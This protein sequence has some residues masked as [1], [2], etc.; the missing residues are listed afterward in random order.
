MRPRKISPSLK[1]LPLSLALGLTTQAGQVFAQEENDEELERFQVTG[2]RID[3]DVEGTSPTVSFDR[4]DIDASGVTTVQ[5]L[6]RELPAAGP[7]TFNTSNDSQDDTS[8][9]TAAISL[10]GLGASST[11]T[12]V[13]GRRVVQSATAQGISTN[14][15]DL[16]S[17]PLAAIERV[18][19]LKDG[20]SPIYGSDA[21]AGVV[22]I[23]LRE[24]YE[25]FEV[26][27]GAGTSSEGDGDERE[28]QAVWGKNYDGGNV[29]I[30]LNYFK[31]DL[32][33]HN[34][35]D[36]A[37]T[38]DNRFRGGG[39]S[40]SSSGNPGSFAPEGQ[41]FRPDP[42]CPPERIRGNFCRFDYGPFLSLIPESERTG[43]FLK[44]DQEITDSITGFIDAQ[45][46]RNSTFLSAS[47]SP[48]FTVTTGITVPENH[49]NNPFPGEGDL[50]FRRRLT[51]FGPRQDDTDSTFFNMTLG[52]QGDFSVAERRWNWEATYQY[53]MNDVN[54]I[55]RAGYINA[56]E[57]QAALDDGTFNPFG[58]QAGPECEG[59]VVGT[60]TV[61]DIL[62]NAGNPDL[63]PDVAERIGTQTFRIAK[64]HLRVYSVQANGDLFD[65]PAGPV[66]ASAGVER[67][68]T[69]IRDEPDEQYL[70]DE[71]VGT[72]ATFVLG[73]R[74]IDAAYAELVVPVTD[75][76][77]IQSAFRWED[78]SD[79]GTT[80]NPKVGLLLS[81]TENIRI[82][83]TYS[84]SFRAPSLAELGNISN[85]SI[86]L[87]DPLRCPVTG[88][89]Q[90]CGFSA[91]IVEFQPTTGLE[92]ETSES[93]N[94]GVAWEPTDN[95]STSLDYWQI[96]VD[97]LIGTNSQFLL[98]QNAD[99]P[100]VVNRF[101]RTEQD[102]E[103]GIPGRIRIINGRRVNFGNEKVEGIDFSFDW[104]LNTSYGRF[105]FNTQWTRFLTHDRLNEPGGEAIDLVG[106]WDVA[107]GL[108]RPEDKL[109]SGVNWN[110]NDFGANFRVNYR[111][112]YDDDPR[113][114]DRRVSARTT[115][116]ASVRY[117]GLPNSTISLSVQNLLDED[118]AFVAA[119]S[120]GF[121]S[122]DNA[123]G[124]FWF[125]RYT[126]RM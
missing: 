25:G 3:R 61:E 20:A 62:N 74:E 82:R 87:V 15:V 75:W 120:T 115:I 84:E 97:D 16:N 68:E 108:G 14:F 112:G 105:D 93:L 22:N 58:C 50:R 48:A 41:A 118:P 90:D 71:I 6:L 94:F 27:L 28:I 5:E 31:R 8:S 83:G 32:L 60:P 92:P 70:R 39:D 54:E 111:D 88:D 65:L 47:P 51:E 29:M 19:I 110:L 103:L 100:D 102:E 119:E 26:T 114:A 122:G 125:L 10:R 64:S 17:I 117:F 53:G 7:G 1:L 45:V 91:F 96:E 106:K 49:P 12:L 2:S 77:E 43:M 86:G 42:E 67:R 52:L 57:L 81:P 99:N 107:N 73:E 109:T 4:E 79:F 56:R 37:R 30:A 63:P 95:I 78:Y 44:V 24:D 104:L 36:F 66:L 55:G 80:T 38:A 34:D 35:R 116:D 72:E 18:D 46:Q 98:D 11:L 69:D 113:A 123:L 21:I 126:Y 9:G 59:A 85:E 121:S 124:Q 13:N 101:P 33:I 40:R 23:I 89:D 76:A